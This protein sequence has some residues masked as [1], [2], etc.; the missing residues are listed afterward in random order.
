M[1]AA[2]RCVGKQ[3]FL[4]LCGLGSRKKKTRPG[5]LL[6]NTG[7]GTSQHRQPLAN[8]LGFFI[9]GADPG[10]LEAVVPLPPGALRPHP[11]G[12]RATQEV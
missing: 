1:F 12:S 10:Q 3:C 7:V 11:R 6:V 9:G 4:D 8:E 2:D 5:T